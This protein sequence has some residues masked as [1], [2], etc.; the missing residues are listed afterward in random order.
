MFL[1]KSSLIILI[2]CLGKNL[3]GS[4]M[5]T[6]AGAAGAYVRDRAA[7]KAAAA[8]RV[9][10]KQ[11]RFVCNGYSWLRPKRDFP[12]KP[13]TEAKIL[14]TYKD[15]CDELRSLPEFEPTDTPKT[16]RS[17]YFSSNFILIGEKNAELRAIKK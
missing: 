10:R 12:V 6:G 15:S 5:S 13:V 1:I 7:E 4:E 17:G 14:K 9:L 8:E 11:S 2:F 3:H 16:R